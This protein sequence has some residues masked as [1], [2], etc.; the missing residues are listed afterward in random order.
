MCLNRNLY[1]HLRNIWEIFSLFTPLFLDFYLS[2]F[3]YTLFSSHALSLSLTH[4]YIFPLSFSSFQFLRAYF[5]LSLS[6]TSN[7]SL[8]FSLYS[9]VFFLNFFCLLYLFF[10]CLSFYLSFFLTLPL[11]LLLIPSFIFFCTLL[12]HFLPAFLTSSLSFDPFVSCFF[13]LHL[14]LF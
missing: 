11:P 9:F 5:S 10:G 8:I 13:F 4:T 1:V 3:V 12:F 7:L 14:L 2:H 6:F